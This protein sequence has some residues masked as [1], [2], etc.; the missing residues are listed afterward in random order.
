ML[1]ACDVCGRRAARRIFPE[2]ECL[3]GDQAAL[4]DLCVWGIAC[5]AILATICEYDATLIRTLEARFAGVAYTG[6][7]LVTEM[8]QQAN[9][10]SFRVRAAARDAIVLHH[11]RCELAA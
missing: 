10:V 7:A 6:E 1:D 4:Q 5:R 11:G 3:E 9:V 2:G 8:W